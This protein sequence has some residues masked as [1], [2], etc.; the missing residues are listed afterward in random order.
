VSDLVTAI[1]AAVGSPVRR[2]A[3]V[4]GGSIGSAARFIAS[5]GSELFVK[6]IDNAPVGMYSSEADGLAWL[7][8]ARALRV[9]RVIAVRDEFPSFIVLE[10]IAPGLPGSNHDDHLGAGVAALHRAGAPHF[11]FARDNLIGTVPQ[12]NTVEQTWSTFYAERRLRPLVGRAVGAGLVSS[13]LASRFD[14]LCD[15]MH[16]LCGPPEVPARLHGDLWSGNAIIDASGAPV[17]LDPAVYGGHREV[18]LAMMRLFGGFSDGVFSAYD[19]AYPLAAGAD[20][21]ISLYQLYPLLVHVILFGRGYVARL[22][23]ALSQYVRA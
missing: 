8:T 14:R 6:H 12:D 2:A 22:D 3:G 17:L 9:P 4:S 16:E 1:G 13:G 18:D 7:A 10:W 23:R 19:E 21:R 20:E 11:G 15:R 5:D